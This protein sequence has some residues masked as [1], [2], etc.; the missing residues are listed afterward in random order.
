MMGQGRQ[1][2]KLSFC[3]GMPNTYW[4]WKLQCSFS[5][6]N[7]WQCL[8]ESSKCHL[9]QLSSQPTNHFSTNLLYLIPLPISNNALTTSLRV[10][11][12]LHILRH[13]RITST[14]NFWLFRLQRSRC[15]LGWILDFECLYSSLW[16]Y[17]PH[18]PCTSL[19]PISSTLFCLLYVPSQWSLH[20]SDFQTDSCT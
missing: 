6:L 15:Q 4:C 3:Q 16:Q 20:S 8:K 17:R 13:L 19:A 14:C 2:H 10:K 7:L 12:F 18:Y 9:P 1:R 11:N 5:P